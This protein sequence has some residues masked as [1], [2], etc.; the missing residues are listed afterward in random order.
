MRRSPE[1]LHLDLDG[2]WPAFG[3]VPVRDLREWG[4]R[5]RFSAPPRVVE[6]FDRALGGELPPFLVYGSGDFHHLSAL[7]VRRRPE[8]TTL[9]SFDNHPDWDVRPPRW[10]CGGW[11][12]RALDRPQVRKVSLW[13]CG[14]FECWWP[15]RLFGN[16][17]AEKS[18]R[19]EVHPWADGRPARDQARRGAILRE[20]WREKFAEFVRQLGATPV[21]V[22]IDLDC[23]REETAATNWENGRFTVEDLLWALGLLGEGNRIQAGDI[24]GAWSPASFARRKQRFASEMDHPK[25]PPRSL[26]ETWRVN[27]PTLARLLPALTHR[28]QNHAERDDEGPE[29]KLRR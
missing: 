27:L 8:L 9:I 17:R 26:E 6:E 3:D 25:L 10:G 2:A 21:Y 23:L 16:W 5:L 1:I 12:N 15:A 19:L 24:C 20:N 4:P 29:Q 22:T 13:G 11:V 18:S 7:W 28:N 14:N